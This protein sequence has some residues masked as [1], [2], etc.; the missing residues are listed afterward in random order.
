MG[1]KVTLI[2]L[3]A[4]AVATTAV[5]AAPTALTPSAGAVA[6]QSFPTTLV[7]LLP[8]TKQ[9]LVSL[10]GKA[11]LPCTA[12]LDRDYVLTP[13]HAGRNLRFSV[14]RLV[15]MR[16]GP[17][18]AKITASYTCFRRNERAAVA[19]KETGAEIKPGDIGI[20]RTR[21]ALHPTSRYQYC[22]FYH[23]DPRCNVVG[24]FDGDASVITAALPALP[25]LKC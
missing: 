24:P 12:T 11:G 20:P 6:R 14:T 17:A 4:A 16:Y 3:V 21:G 9:A 1:A 15:M 13:L 19:C 5:T 18:Q 23:D 10:A 7:E 25:P 8:A 22:D 2:A